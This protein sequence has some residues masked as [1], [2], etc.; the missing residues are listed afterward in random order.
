V[1]TFIIYGCG[2]LQYTLRHIFASC[3]PLK[4]TE[5]VDLC[6]ICNISVLIFDESFQGYYLHGKS[7]YGSAEISQ[8]RLRKALLEERI[9]KS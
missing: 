7:P 6:S 3:V 5:F 2:L 1:T 9:G 8:E 4:P